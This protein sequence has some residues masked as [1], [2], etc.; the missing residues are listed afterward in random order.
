MKWSLKIAQFRGIPV[1]IH[2]TFLLI[3]GWVALVHWMQGHNVATT[4]QGIIFVLLIFLCV[5]LHEF[6]HALT[7]ARY[8]IKTR[9]ITLLPIGGVASLERMP[10]R[11]REELLVA[12]AGPL[13]NVVI[14]AL[15]GVW[16]VVT[17]SFQP[18]AELSVTGGSL[19][20]RLMVVNLFLVAFNLLPAFPMDGG[21]VLRA[22]LA[23]RMNYVRATQIAASIGQGMAV[24]FGFL[25][26][27]GN[28]FLL[29]IAAFVWMGA[30]QE[31]HMAKVKFAFD[32]IPV[33][34]AMI[35]DFKTIRADE[36]L[37][38]A[39]ELVI[40]SSQQDF[41]VVEHDEV[42][43]MLE[44]KK[45]MEGLSRLG[46]DAKVRVV[47]DTYFQSVDG[48]E[49]LQQALTQLQSCRCKV[50]PVLRDGRLTGLLTMQNL[51]EFMMI[52]TALQH[53]RA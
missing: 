33:S 28:P 49:M 10:D 50:M 43:G 30:A 5:V 13:V 11:P 36:P 21:R 14:A 29:F 12:L 44:Q 17:N 34:N 7:A 31:A 25:A 51:G 45:L 35:T 41:P 6:G 4:V 9:S 16:L 47:M 8:H 24:L 22:T 27:L 1:Y 42:V 15:L 32:G 20:E 18:F 48:S 39:V 38:R 37:S 2:A 40:A 26:L 23:M 46:R 52:H 53:Q 3:I 19:L